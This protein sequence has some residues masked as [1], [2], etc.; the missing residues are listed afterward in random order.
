[1]N[2]ESNVHK[3]VRSKAMPKIRDVNDILQLGRNVLAAG[4]A[5]VALG[6][7]ADQY[8]DWGLWRDYNHV[9]KFVKKAYNTDLNM[10]DIITRPREGKNAD[11]FINPNGQIKLKNRLNELNDS[12]RACVIVNV[13]RS[14]KAKSTNAS[15]ESL[16]L[17]KE[18]TRCEIG[19]DGDDCTKGINI[20]PPLQ[21]S[22]E[23]VFDLGAYYVGKV[24]GFYETEEIP[25]EL[26]QT[27]GPLHVFIVDIEGLEGENK[28]DLLQ[29]VEELIPVTSVFVHSIKESPNNVDIAISVDIHKMINAF[30]GKNA[31]RPQYIVAWMPGLNSYG[32]DR[33]DQLENSGIKRED[34]CEL[35]LF[36][37]ERTGNKLKE[38]TQ[39]QE[40]GNLLAI[41]DAKLHL[42]SYIVFGVNVGKRL[43]CNITTIG[44]IKKISF[45][46]EP[47]RL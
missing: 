11:F 16:L 26:K 31:P 32:G 36:G 6:V 10:I 37:N 33:W 2:K 44:D 24:K 7:G 42:P 22:L 39:K 17:S 9:P 4:G 1:M 5:F 12:D 43:R 18:G 19:L 14:R 29:Y 30:R 45:V 20:S 21:P 47:K 35:P 8:F 25:T 40:Y 13:G 15:I 3:N 28:R 23:P 27:K 34:V 38:E 46:K 41:V